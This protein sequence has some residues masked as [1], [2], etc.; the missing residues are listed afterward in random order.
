MRREIAGDESVAVLASQQDRPPHRQGRD[1]KHFPLFLF[2]HKEQLGV[3][4]TIPIFEAK[5]ITIMGKDK[6]HF[7]FWKSIPQPAA[8]NG[9][10]R[11]LPNRKAGAAG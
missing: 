1:T 7:F 2:F 9:V 4:K 11:R 10:P 8:R 6:P 5:A 3:K